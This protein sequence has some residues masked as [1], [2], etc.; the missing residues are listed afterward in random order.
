MI[1]ETYIV[2]TDDSNLNFVINKL[3]EWATTDNSS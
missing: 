1:E 2:E 3:K